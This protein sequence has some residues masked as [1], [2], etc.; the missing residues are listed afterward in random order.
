MEKLATTER[1]SCRKGRKVQ[2]LLLLEKT[3]RMTSKELTAA[4]GM[5]GSNL[6]LYTNRLK[7]NGLIDIYDGSKFQRPEDVNYKYHY[8]S[9]T[10]AGLEL[11]SDLGK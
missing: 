11:I 9:I 5:V 2:I 7:K 4:M 8:H 1:E 6:T 3:K 10:D